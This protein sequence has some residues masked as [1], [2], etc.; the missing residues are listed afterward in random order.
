VTDIN[1]DRTS[2]STPT[3]RG[4]VAAAS[5][6]GPARGKRRWLSPGV[7]RA[8]QIVVSGALLGFIVWF[9][10]GQFANLSDVT[11]VLRTLTWGEMALLL[12]VAI[13]NLLTYWVVVVVATPGMT[14]MQAG[15]LT[16]S[17]TAVSN[18]IPG[19]GAIAVGL[20]YTMMSSWGF[21]RSRTTLSVVVT[22]IWNSFVKLGMPILALALLA[23]Q[24]QAGAGRTVAALLGLAG[25]AAAVAVFALVL[26]SEAFAART[27]IAAGR[28]A[29]RLLAAFKRE[30]V[31]GWDLAVVKWRSRV[32]GLV[33]HH[34]LALSVTT[35]VSHASLYFVLL[36]ALR[37]TGV[38][39]AE[40]GWAEA[41]AVFAFAR[42]VTAI[43]LTPGGVGVVELAL[44]AGLTRAG[45]TDANVV[46][47]VL[48]FRLLTYLLPIVIGA[49]TH[50]H[51]RK[52]TSWRNSAPPLSDTA[53]TIIEP[54]QDPDRATLANLGRDST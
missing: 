13:W 19:G 10:F 42:L 1:R 15:V 29:S 43:P 17:T 52:N 40:V 23:L 7:K 36:V 4:A 39:A 44:I 30:P 26:R 38:P 14:V 35:V 24:G 25:L 41:L 27:G 49:F 21:S 16:Q 37:I 46:A 28:V 18:A 47:A 2:A 3:E 11:T 6:P 9:V 50:I 45:G 53:V 20:T 33:R 54:D 22:G 32:I 51:W 5:E 12:L 8:L 48:L 31:H 34:W